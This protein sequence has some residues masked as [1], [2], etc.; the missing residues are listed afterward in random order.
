[1][2]KKLEVVSKILILPNGEILGDKE[3][4]EFVEYLA[5]NTDSG[6]VHCLASEKLPVGGQGFLKI[7]VTTS[8]PVLL[9][10]LFGNLIHLNIIQT[11]RSL[12]SFYSFFS[13]FFLFSLAYTQLEAED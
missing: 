10:F 11:L 7:K 5:E 13:L 4:R 1:M 3:N 12:R 2:K 9:V 8:S 6:E